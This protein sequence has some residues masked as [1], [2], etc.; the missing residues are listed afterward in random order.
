MIKS[1]EVIN[2]TD[3]DVV[4]L[5]EESFKFPDLE[6]TEKCRIPPSGIMTRV[7]HNTMVEGKILV[8]GRV[9]NITQTTYGEVVNL[10]PPEEGK[11]Y[12]VSKLVAEAMQ[13]LRDDLVILSGLLKGPNRVILGCRSL[14]KLPKNKFVYDGD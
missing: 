5:N 7:K 13:G 3:H 4:I 6:P 11:L 2:L 12:I 14:A 9:V 8:Q 10:P 1:V